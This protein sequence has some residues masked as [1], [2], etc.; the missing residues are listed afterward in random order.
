MYLIHWLTVTIYIV[1]QTVKKLK[2][3]LLYSEQSV[4]VRE[5]WDEIV[6]L[7]DKVVH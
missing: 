2:I 3:D 6:L 4:M 7:S 5:S 1:V